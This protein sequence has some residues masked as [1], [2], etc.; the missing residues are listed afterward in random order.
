MLEKETIFPFFGLK[1]RKRTQIADYR[2]VVF[3]GGRNEWPRFARYVGSALNRATMSAT[4]ITKQKEDGI[5]TCSE[6]APYRRALF[7]TC[8]YV[9]VACVQDAYSSQHN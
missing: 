9:P 7:G 1:N 5:P 8:G 6:C 2:L 4:P 3:I